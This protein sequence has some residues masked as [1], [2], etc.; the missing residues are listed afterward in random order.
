MKKIILIPPYHTYGDC[1]SV[2]SLLYYLLEYYEIVYFYINPEDFNV[3][4]YYQNYLH[5]DT[6]FNKRILIITDIHKLI[7]SGGYNEYHVCDT[8]TNDWSGPATKFIDLPNINK[9]Y[10][11]NDLNPLYNKLNIPDNHR[12]SPNSHLP[13]NKLE[14]NHMFYYKLVGLNNNVRMDYFNYVRNIEIEKEYKKNILLR[15]NLGENDKYNIINDP[16]YSFNQVKKYIKNDYPVI[17]ISNTSPFVGYL[18]YLLEGSET[19]HFVEGNN[20][21]FFYHSQYKNIFEYDKEINF[22]VWVRNREWKEFNLD[23]AWKMMSEPKLN[24]WNFIFEEN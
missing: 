14:I 21:N 11:F 16:I 24:K 9:D 23:K 19:I 8:S 7:N 13:N 20:V 2:I 17:N 18:T 5:N 1:L 15:Y 10:Y 3:V 4:K 12:Q 6:K 22:H